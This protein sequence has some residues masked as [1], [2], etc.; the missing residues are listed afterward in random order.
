[1]NS[2]QPEIPVECAQFLEAFSK[3]QRWVGKRREAGWL[4]FRYDFDKDWID[5]Y[6]KVHGFV[7]KQ[8][9]RALKETKSSMT[10][11]LDLQPS[12]KRCSLIDEMAKQIRDP[13]KLRYQIL[14]VFL[15]ARDTTSIA[16]G[17]VLFQLARHPH[18]WTRLRQISV[19]LGD[20]PLTFE[21]LKSLVDFR[22]VLHETIRLSGPAAR[23]W[24]VASRDTILPV[25]GGP[26]QKSPVF[27][28]KGTTVVMGTWCVHHN[29]D[30]WGDDVQ[31][32]KPDRWIGRKPQWEFVPFLGGPRICPAQ[33]QVLTHAIYI[34]VRLTQRF[35]SIENRD[36]VFEY[37]EKFTM[38]FESRNG[39]KVALKEA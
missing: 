5:S 1:M 7:D 17:N 32:F 16:V 35:E 38:A 21:K 2:L 9:E 39:V 13:I 28:P 33:Q 8:V 19:A 25:G 18:I 34:L 24:R 23:V 30:I 14:G 29:K 3:A 36:P 4:R 22:Y 27:I 20:E 11:D 12:R 37:I 6:T 15:P 26:D 10:V 31:E